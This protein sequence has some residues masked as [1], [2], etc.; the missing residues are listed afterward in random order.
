M[1]PEGPTEILTQGLLYIALA[2]ALF[3]VARLMVSPFFVYSDGQWHG[4]KF[5]YKEPKLAFHAYVS[6]QVNNEVFKFRFRDAPPFSF[7]EYK[8]EIDAPANFA[9]PHGTPRAMSALH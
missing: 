3:F 8:F 1:P 9:R 7:I 2:W 4:G 5:V 6:H